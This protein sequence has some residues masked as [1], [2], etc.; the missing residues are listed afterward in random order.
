MVERS[1]M[2]RNF[3]GFEKSDSLFLGMGTIRPCWKEDGTWPDK[4]MTLT[5]VARIS[6]TSGWA[7]SRCSFQRWS[8]P[9]P[10]PLG[11]DDATRAV[12]T[13]E[14]FKACMISNWYLDFLLIF[15]FPYFLISMIPVI[16][17]L[18]SI[19]FLVSPLSSNCTLPQEKFPYEQ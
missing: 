19:D 3:E 18:I 9:A 11:K 14:N 10:F 1:V 6:N 8:R 12:M 2:P 17:E 5:M 16:S 13:Y 15:K 4:S 7:K